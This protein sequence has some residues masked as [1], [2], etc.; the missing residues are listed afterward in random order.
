MTA[1]SP[2]RWGAALVAAVLAL[3]ASLA[4]SREVSAQTLQVDS[5]ETTNAFPAGAVFSIFARTS[6]PPKEVRLRYS[7][8]PDGT[9]A[10]RVAECS[11]TN[12]IG[13]R[14]TVGDTLDT[15][16]I[17]GA[18]VTFSWEFTLPDGTRLT[19][20]PQRFVYED[21]RFEWNTES[22]G[23]VTVYYYGSNRDLARRVL[24]AAGETLDR[25]GG[26]L[27]A[28]VAFPVK[29]FL[30]EDASTMRPAILSNPRAGVVTLGEVYF[31]DTAMVAADVAP[32]D[33]TRH[34]VAHIVIREATRGPFGVPAWLNEGTA[35]W[36]QEEPL[37]GELDA[38]DAAIA[39]DRVLPLQV[40]SSSSAAGNPDTVSLFY[41]QSYSVVNYLITT[42]GE[43]KFRQLFA[44]FKEGATTDKALRTVYGLGV[45]ELENAWRASV[46]LP[47]RAIPSPTA[48]A[49]PGGT[50]TPVGATA[51][52]QTTGDDGGFPVA[53]VVAIAAGAVALAGAI[54]GLGV[55]AA[56]KAS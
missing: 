46:G 14:A 24:A 1:R 36:A 17:P 12:P 42:Y 26:I 52:Q 8:A 18:E 32:E 16:M 37:G 31:S 54:V 56:R 44:V 48:A 2:A 45:R 7:I 15:F 43:E 27:G 29:V 38:L 10:M 40:L 35:V 6:E 33:V 20:D 22:A 53:V 23:N 39:R 51:G 50:R 55:I 28:R 4:F 30:Y 21:T 13:C 25:L 47:P 49:T 19:T 5:V 11:G 9:E 34:E 3:G 41:G